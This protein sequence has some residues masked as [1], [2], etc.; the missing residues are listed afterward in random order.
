[1]KT[2]RFGIL[3]LVLAFMT[4]LMAG[5]FANY[6]RIKMTSG[7][8]NATIAEIKENWQEYDIYYAGLSTGSPSAIMFGPR[9]DGLRLIGK[10]W[11]PVT[12]KSVMDEIIGWLNSYVNYPPTLYQIVSSQ[13]VFFGYIYTSSTEQIVGKLIDPKTME[14]ENIPLPPIDYGPGAGRF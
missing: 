8:H 13:G 6:A 12:D 7:D 1:M 14:M 2:S 10:K 4:G 5:C 3:F 9:S 11:M